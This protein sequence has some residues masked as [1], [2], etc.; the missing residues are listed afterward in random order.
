MEHYEN[1]NFNKVIELTNE[2]IELDS[3][4]V[5]AFY[6]RGAAKAEYEDW[7]GARSDLTTALRLCENN[8]ES[9]CDIQGMIYWK[10]GIVYGLEDKRSMA[11]KDLKKSVDLNYPDAFEIYAKL[12]R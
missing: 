11:C 6:L 8:Q 10:R 3:E 9:S 2:V 1:K 4:H 12:C 5:T 7:E